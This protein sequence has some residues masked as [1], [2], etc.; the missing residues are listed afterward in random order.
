MW[1]WPATLSEFQRQNT[2]CC[3]SDTFISHPVSDPDPAN[4]D[5]RIRN[6]I[7]IRNVY[8]GSGLV[9]GKNFYF[10]NYIFLRSLSPRKEPSNIEF[11]WIQNNP[12]CVARRREINTVRG[13]SYFSL[14][15]NLTPHPPLRPPASVWGLP[16][17]SNNLSTVP[18]PL[19]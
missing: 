2:Q 6:P 16:S 4:S 19:S 14:L 1:C 9:T 3:G 10:F 15:Q 7:R 8:F 11:I 12:F 17:Y 18:G 5:F 13:Q